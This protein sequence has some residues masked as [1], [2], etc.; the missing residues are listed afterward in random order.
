MEEEFKGSNGFIRAN[1]IQL[2]DNPKRR[3]AI[4]SKS[5]LEYIEELATEL[6]GE[7][8]SKGEKSKKEALK[9]DEMTN[10]LMKFQKINSLH[11]DALS[12][13]KDCFDYAYFLYLSNLIPTFV[14]LEDFDW[15]INWIHKVIEKYPDNAFFRFLYAYFAAVIPL[16]FKKEYGLSTEELSEQSKIAFE[17]IKKIDVTAVIIECLTNDPN[18]IMHALEQRRK[19]IL[20]MIS[21]YTV[22]SQFIFNNFTRI[23]AAVS[24]ESFVSALASFSDSIVA[25]FYLVSNQPDK[26]E[27]KLNEAIKTYKDNAL[28]ICQIAYLRINRDANKAEKE[29]KTA[30]DL[31]QNQFNGI[32]RLK[33]KVRFDIYLGLAYTNHKKGRYDEAEKKYNDALQLHLGQYFD[34]LVLLN[35]G[36]TRFENGDYLGALDDLSKASNEPS[37][38]ATAHSNLGL[39]YL[40]QGLY[41][42][43]ESELVKSLDINPNLVHAYYNLGVLYNEEG[44]KQRAEKLFKTAT[45]V[46]KNFGEARDALKKLRGT[47]LRNLGGDWYDWW[48]GRDSTRLKKG[49]GTAVVVLIGILVARANYN[50]H[51]DLE[52][53]T[54]L[55]AVLAINILIILLP[56]LSKLK[57]GPIELDVQSKGERPV[58]IEAHTIDSLNPDDTRSVTGTPFVLFDFILY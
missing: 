16:T 2:I 34:S 51:Y 52:V 46:N 25:K 58:S 5:G 3:N 40:K 43:A 1:L 27:E 42:K 4:E 45:A 48:F 7:V 20:K 44:N 14:S 11:I 56:I 28:A 10:V 55:F 41:G 12:T 37:L 32:Q 21:S 39:V 47:E 26:Y 35:R 17:A 9:N 22:L 19:I 15:K 36:R 57:M 53:P 6:Q 23:V 54:S 8:H 33:N 31:I 38:S 30:N 49:V 18:T 24:S 13:I 50:I 29:F